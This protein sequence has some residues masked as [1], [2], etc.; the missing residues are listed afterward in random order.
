MVSGYA[1]SGLGFA[2]RIVDFR[3]R[4]LRVKSGLKIAAISALVLLGV[5]ITRETFSPYTA[6]YFIVPKARLTVDGRRQP[7]WLHRGNHRETL[8]LTRRDEGRAESYL[9]WVPHDRQ[10]IVWS[11]GNWTAP[12]FPAFRIGDVNPPCWTFS[13]SE[14]PSQKLTLPVRNLVAEPGSVEFI[15]DDGS[16]LRAS[17]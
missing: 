12:R 9:I 17:W 10:G 11:C 14:A 15:A 16:R 3:C 4:I 13:A 8:F 2:E 7:G 1:L 6:W 5:V